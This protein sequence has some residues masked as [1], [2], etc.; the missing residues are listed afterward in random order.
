M[1]AGEELDRLVIVLT[2]VTAEVE[3]QRTLAEQQEF[4]AMVEHFLRDRRGFQ[5][6]WSEAQ[7]LVA[8]IVRDDPSPDSA[9][10]RSLHTLKGNAGYFGLNRISA[11][12]PRARERD[13]RTS[14]RASDRS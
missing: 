4:S 5:S 3:R 12:L 11:P 10:K 13:G 9:V 14:R 2:H 8:D 7:T 1:L 6:F